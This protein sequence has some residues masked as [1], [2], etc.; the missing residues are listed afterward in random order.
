MRPI[1]INGRFLTQRITGTQRYAHE[2]LRHLDAVLDGVPANSTGPSPRVTLLVPHSD[3][4]IPVF[5]NIRVL[6]VGRWTGQLWEQLELPF[7]ARGGILFSMVGGA[8]L[9]HRRNILTLHDAA[10]FAMP[11]S[12]SA[13]FRHWY[14]FLYGRL[15][16]TALHLFT[17]SNFSRAELVKWCGVKPEKITVTYLGSDHALR[18]RPDIGV[19]ARNKLESQKYVLAVGSRNP[20]KNLR[21][22]LTAYR[23]I[24]DSDLKI[25]IAGASYS[26]VFG[27]QGIVDEGVRDLGYVNDSELRSLYENA[28]CF[29]FPSYYEGFGLPPLEAL[30][31]GCPTVVADGSALREIFHEVAFL[32]N[33]DSSEDIA[34]KTLQACRSNEE[35]RKRFRDFALQFRWEECATITW[36][37]ILGFADS[38]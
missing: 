22:L 23:L 37:T 3:E 12:F 30:A 17:V 5:R 1:F 14:R 31:L 21:G 36:S 27:S 33:P 11:G 19:L 32:C 8:P 20:S 35:D 24:R 7:Y 15:C 13:A 16:H 34:S 29:V 4:P 2:L 9:L 25:V 10:V 38:I 26:K 28:A 18:S 6:E